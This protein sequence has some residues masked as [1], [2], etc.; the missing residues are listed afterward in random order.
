MITTI[1]DD[2]FMCGGVGVSGFGPT[3]VLCCPA[4]YF[5]HVW[6]ECV[7]AGGVEVGRVGVNSGGL[8]L[9]YPVLCQ[10]IRSHMC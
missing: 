1:K 10:P 5:A 2:T 8:W 9:Q 3:A 4:V 6:R 7:G